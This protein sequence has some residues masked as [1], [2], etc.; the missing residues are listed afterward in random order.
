MASMSKAKV[1]PFPRANLPPKKG[2][3]SVWLDSQHAI[4]HGDYYERPAAL[5]FDSLRRMVDRT[6]VLGAAVF[7]RIRQI[8][9]F[10]RPEHGDDPGFRIRHRDPDHEPDGDEKTSIEALT[11]FL[12][13]CGWEW[14]PRRRK[15]MRRDNFA[16]FMS[17]LVRDSL[18]LD[19][20]S[21]ETEQ[22]NDKAKGIDGLYAVDGSTIRLC[23][24]EGYEGDD[25]VFALQVAQGQIATAYTY[26]DLIYEP[27]NVR[28]DILSGG[29]G[30]SEV[31]LMVQVV[32]GFLNAMSYNIAGFDR[33]Q[34][35]KGMLHLSG[36][37]AERD[38]N[39]FKRYWNSM[40]T[41]VNNAWT[42]PVMVS[43]DQ[44]SKAAFERFGVDHDEMAF[45]RWMTFLVSMICALFGMAPE[46]INFES[47][48]ANKSSLS[49]SDTNEKLTS[50][51]D[52]GLLTL[53]AYFES[54]FTDFIV[55]DF[56]DKYLFEW[57]GL[58]QEDPAV[59]NDWRKL[60]L[61]LNEGRQSLNLDPLDGALGDAPLNP[62]LIGPWLQLQ[63][64]E[65]GDFGQPP[66]DGEAA[67]GEQAQGDEGD[68]GEPKASGDFGK[69]LPIYSLG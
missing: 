43:Q 39:S 65:G 42:L 62:S 60:T 38:L 55:A 49:G 69:S 57:T 46:E 48:A 12:S 14:N 35:P 64:A 51:R 50:S 15:A 63:Q 54:T 47:F 17:K 1:I 36:N 53:L 52:N 13:N 21:I 61:T 32:T 18:T 68:F 58:K 34:I 33:N 8:Q 19:A 20:L 26:E 2:M 9:R 7:T 37:F 30:L 45:S 22:R 4:R 44:E 5:S 27:R 24:E 40:V 16:H 56:S 29:Y 6:P 67:P 59:T 23:T 10:C 28:T 25:A 66:E 11:K 3:Q 31:E 41:G